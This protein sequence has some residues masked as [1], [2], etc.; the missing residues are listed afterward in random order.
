MCSSDLGARLVVPVARTHEKAPAKLGVTSL[1]KPFDSGKPLDPAQL[2]DVIST[3]ILPTLADFAPSWN[4]AKEFKIDVSRHLRAIINGDAKF[5][6]FA[7]RIVPDRGVDEGWTVRATL[8][9]Q[10]A[11]RL[12]IDTYTDISE[13]AK[14]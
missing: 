3:T 4:P 13:A 7:L 12:E 6:G 9:A 8:P 1:R 10:P 14:K 2:G 5:N 11:L